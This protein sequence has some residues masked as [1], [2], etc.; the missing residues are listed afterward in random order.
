MIEMTEWLTKV[1]NS[2]GKFREN[3]NVIYAPN[4]D[5]AKKISEKQY[6]DEEVIVVKKDIAIKKMK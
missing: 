2:K 3:G 5:W 4:K 6:P 1:K